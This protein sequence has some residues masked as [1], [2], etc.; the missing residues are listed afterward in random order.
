MI[1]H[2]FLPFLF[3][4]CSLLASLKSLILLVPG[5]NMVVHIRMNEEEGMYYKIR[6]TKLSLMFGVTLS[7]LTNYSQQLS[8]PLHHQFTSY[9]FHILLW[10]KDL[11]RIMDY[12]IEALLFSHLTKKILLFTFNL[13]FTN[14]DVLSIVLLALKRAWS[15]LMIWMISSLVLLHSF[16]FY[17]F[18][19]IITTIN[20]LHCLLKNDSFHQDVNNSLI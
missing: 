4:P 19:I 18:H 12:L 13:I 5:Q 17:F 14:L 11:E 1:Y 2:S 7:S 15:V 6:L 3:R 20:A 16:H 10:I 8:D 9:T